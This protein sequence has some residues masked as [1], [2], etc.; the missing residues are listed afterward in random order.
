MISKKLSGKMRK[1]AVVANL[2]YRHGIC[3][4]VLMKTIKE[5]SIKTG[6]EEFLIMSAFLI[7][8]P[9]VLTQLSIQSDS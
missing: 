3:L 2:R 8:D 6:N 1:E 9:I 4:E 5:T 7:T